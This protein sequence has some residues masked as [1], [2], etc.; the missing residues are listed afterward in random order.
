[1]L[2]NRILI[3]VALFVLIWALPSGYPR[4]G[5]S[6]INKGGL[7]VCVQD[8]G[9]CDLSQLIHGEAMNLSIEMLLVTV[10][11]NSDRRVR[12]APADFLGVTEAGQAT[13]L[14]MPL[15]ESIELRTKLKNVDLAT[16]EQVKGYLFFPLLEGKLRILMHR[17][18][19]SFQVRLY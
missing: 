10:S 18:Q 8:K 11:N 19:P 15:F 4:A 1:M 3:S 9:P 2:M 7:E 13:Q 16:G 6:C 5:E 17:G 14:D 12:I